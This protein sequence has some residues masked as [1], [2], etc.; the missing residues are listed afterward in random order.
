LGVTSATSDRSPK[1]ARFTLAVTAA[2]V[3]GLATWRA[4]GSVEP[5]YALHAEWAREIAQTGHVSVPHPLF[6]FLTVLV[7]ALLPSRLA[8][9]VRLGPDAAPADPSFLLAAMIVGT[10]AWVALA[11]LVYR[12]LRTADGEAP[13]GSRR[14]A[15]WAPWPAA[16]LA[17]S[18]LLLGPITV[19]TWAQHQLYLGYITPAVFHNPTV[20]L[21][22]PLAL[23]W[24][25][26]VARARPGGKQ[27]ALVAALL[28]AAATLAK[29]SF[30][31]A[32]LPALALWL[33]LAWRSKRAVDVRA[34]V[35]SLLTG[36]LV[37][38][39]QAWL[40]GGSGDASL[41]VVAPL[42]VM[43]FYSPRWE[44][45]LLFVLSVAFPLAAAFALRR[46]ALRDGPLQLAWLT[47]VV[48]AGYGY[49]LAEADP[50]T[51]SGNW[52]WS[53]QIALFVLLAES[54][55][56]L[57]ARGEAVS[58][59]A[60]RLAW[61]AFGLQLACGLLWYTAEVVQPHEWW[62]PFPEGD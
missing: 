33:A 7:H 48:A 49:V 20:A 30:T 3:F 9:L 28:T 13:A 6:H 34:G 56:L 21:V 42:E 58:P 2:T 54:L 29:P 61:L 37:V 5:D 53:G 8:A 16:G 51:G 45:P 46:V 62:F 22:K 32:F 26:S 59:R 38:A 50:N 1:R 15:G 19:L 35:A 39:A 10:G 24:F 17:L 11:L 4:A 31:V 40:R 44:M 18:L 47:F 36:A 12:R 25:W 43:G 23:A 57:R 60:R 27:N 52:L 14:P 41:L 55:L